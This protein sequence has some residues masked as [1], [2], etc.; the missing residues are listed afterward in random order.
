M[1]AENA[2]ELLDDAHSTIMRLAH[3]AERLALANGDGTARQVADA[4]KRA[5]SILADELRPEVDRLVRERNAVVADRDRWADALRHCAH[6]AL[7]TTPADA[8][9]PDG[10]ALNVTDVLDQASDACAAAHDIARAV[11]SAMGDDPDS[12]PNGSV[13]AIGDAVEARVRRLVRERDAAVATVAGRTTPP[14]PAEAAAHKAASGEWLL[15]MAPTITTLPTQV[16]VDPPTRPVAY[17]T[18]YVPLDR[19]RR[20]CAWPAVTP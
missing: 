9:D 10:L 14:T 15:V 12:A 18:L 1:P 3:G 11:W 13:D 20:P 5:A 2:L 19:L 6:E 7:V 16:V 4:Y 8:D 17:V